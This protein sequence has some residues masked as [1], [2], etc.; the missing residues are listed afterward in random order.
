MDEQPVLNSVVRPDSKHYYWRISTRPRHHV[1]ADTY[2]KTKN[3][4]IPE[5]VVDLAVKQGM[6]LDVFV[7]DVEEVV[8]VTPEE[9]FKHMTD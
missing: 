9:Y 4:Y 8:E 3:K 5:M 7:Q 1:G 6:L 2:F